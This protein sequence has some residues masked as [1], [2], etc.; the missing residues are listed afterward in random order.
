MRYARNDI[1]STRKTL[2]LPEDNGHIQINNLELPW[3][4]YVYHFSVII[5]NKGHHYQDDTTFRSSLIRLVSYLRTK[6]PN[7]LLI[8]RSTTVGHL[9]CNNPNLKPLSNPYNAF[10]LPYHWGEIH[11]QN[12]IA[13]EIIE[14]V[15]GVYWN[16]ENVMETRID[17]HIGGQDCIRWCIPGPSDIWLNLLFVLLKELKI[18]Q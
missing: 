7:T 8:F 15:G 10:E 16:L 4:S 1:L 3:T 11:K 2:V 14:A 5:L 13:K 6:N 18:N 9:N 12:M 17:D